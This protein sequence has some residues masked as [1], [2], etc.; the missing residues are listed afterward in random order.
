M[1]VG[2]VAASVHALRLLQ[3]QMAPELNGLVVYGLGGGARGG[4]ELFLQ[5]GSSLQARGRSLKGVI[6]N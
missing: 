3:P 2:D 1:G 4:D 5:P 6:Q